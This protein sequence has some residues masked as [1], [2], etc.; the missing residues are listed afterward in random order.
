MEYEHECDF[1]S[2]TLN[3]NNMY[4]STLCCYGRRVYIV[5]GGFADQ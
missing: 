5:I 3:N 2:E 1:D 4:F